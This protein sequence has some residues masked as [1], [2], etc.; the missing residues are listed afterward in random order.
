MK[1]FS[2]HLAICLLASALITSSAQS[3][4]PLR[5]QATASPDQLFVSFSLIDRQ[6]IV[7]L[8]TKTIPE[9]EAKLKTATGA[10]IL[11]KAHPS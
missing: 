6:I 9:F 8:V 5:S 7:P 10:E 3:T 11:E 4:E 1:K 2:T